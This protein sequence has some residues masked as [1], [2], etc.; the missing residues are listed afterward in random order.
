MALALF[1]T[2]TRR[3]QEFVPL[4]SGRVRMYNCGPTV[5]SFAHLGNFATFILADLL[6]R[7]L[8]YSGLQVLQVMNITDVGHLTDDSVADAR[9]EDKLEKQ[10]REE[11]KD[12]WQIA[13]YYEEAFHRDRKL[14]HLRDA[15][16]Y[17]RATEHVPE[18]IALIEE[19]LAKGLAYR[20]GDQVYF[21]IPRFPRYGVLSGNTPEELLA[22]AG[23]RVEED[24]HKRNPL[25]FC[26]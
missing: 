25:D 3:K 10:A 5:Y 19:L 24:P 15:H 1:N 2:L 20:A 16:H 17:P 14:L 18:M 4:E 26:L 13:R 21:E 22:G 23:N 12:P 8:E 6:R 11:K 7:S 9:G